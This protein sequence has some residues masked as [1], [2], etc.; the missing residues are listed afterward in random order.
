MEFLQHNLPAETAL[1]TTTPTS[2]RFEYNDS[3]VVAIGVCE[4]GAPIRDYIVS[5]G[6]KAGPSR[7][8]A[9]ARR[10]NPGNHEKFRWIMTISYN[11]IMGISKGGSCC[12]CTEKLGKGDGRSNADLHGRAL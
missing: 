10:G 5:E 4:K 1:S 12:I 3:G 9:D 7:N 6:E 11:T 8:P 2:I